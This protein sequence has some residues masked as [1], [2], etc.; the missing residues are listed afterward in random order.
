MSPVDSAP[1][2]IGSIRTSELRAQGLRTRVLEA[3]SARDEEAAVFLHGSPGSADDWADLLPR[4]GAFTRAI[5]F[6]LPGF[7][8]ADKPADWEYS[9]N[10]YATFI[11]GALN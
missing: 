7:G 9:P 10:S 5:A 6:D 8:K 4:V 3:G 1:A 2:L 11:A